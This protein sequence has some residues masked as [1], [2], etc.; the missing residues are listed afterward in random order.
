MI[1]CLMHLDYLYGSG[2]PKYKQQIV[3]QDLISKSIHFLVT[4]DLEKKLK[5]PRLHCY[6]GITVISDRKRVHFQVDKLPTNSI[7]ILPVLYSLCIS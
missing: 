3:R 4:D 2:G 7:D 5:V 6:S 1:T